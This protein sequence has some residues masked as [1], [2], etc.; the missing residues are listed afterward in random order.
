LETPQSHRKLAINTTPA[1]S[2]QL[3]LGSE[4]KPSAQLCPTPSPPACLPLT[5]ERASDDGVEEFFFFFL[6]FLFFVFFIFL[7]GEEVELVSLR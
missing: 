6:F 2:A 7:G 1:Q 5:I 4:L 3:R